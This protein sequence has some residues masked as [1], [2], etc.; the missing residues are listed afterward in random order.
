MEFRHRVEHVDT[1]ASGIVHFSRYASL[2]ETAA[3]EELERRGAGLGVLEA[4]GLELRVRDL[5][6]TYR[7]AARFRDGLLLVPGVENVGPASVKVGVK[8]YREGPG[9]EPLLLASGSLDLAVVNRESGGPVCIPETLKAA[10]QQ[11]P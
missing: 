8:V 11:A 6:I 4:Q 9:P 3:L 7:S 2:L 5:R 1:D 10:L